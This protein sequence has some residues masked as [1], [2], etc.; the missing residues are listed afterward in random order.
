MWL[1]GR[2]DMSWIKKMLALS[3][4][5]EENTDALQ[6][7]TQARE[8]SAAAIAA[9]SVRLDKLASNTLGL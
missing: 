6:E 3:A 7:N 4:V 2:T 8:K 9:L 1:T 5:S